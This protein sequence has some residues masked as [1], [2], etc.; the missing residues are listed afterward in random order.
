M[1][2]DPTIFRSCDQF[3]DFGKNVIASAVRHVSLVRLQE[4]QPLSGEQRLAKFE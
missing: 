3:G 4:G 2:G 1:A